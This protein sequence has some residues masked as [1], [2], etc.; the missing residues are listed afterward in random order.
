MYIIIGVIL[1]PVGFL[2]ILSPETVIQ[3][4]DCMKYDTYVEPTEKYILVVRV[5]GV[6]GVILGIISILAEIFLF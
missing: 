4:Q 6:L 5:V 2:M 1:I 3:I